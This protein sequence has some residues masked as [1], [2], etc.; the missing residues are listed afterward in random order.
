MN[1]QAIVFWGFIAL[2]VLGMA[3]SIIR[4]DYS[5]LSVLLIPLIVFGVVLL[6]YKFPPR[7]G[8]KTPKIKPSAKTMAK[9]TGGRKQTSAKKRKEY[10]FYVIE[11]QKGKNNDD[12]P[13]YH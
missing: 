3:A 2:A 8:V 13:K 11:G 12:M 6:L 9:T 1:K 7:R 4:G 10:P 5:T